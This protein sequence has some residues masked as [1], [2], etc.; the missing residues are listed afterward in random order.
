MDT[1]LL[2]L[3]ELMSQRAQPTSEQWECLTLRERHLESVQKRMG[4]EFCE[5][6]RDAV[7]E[8]AQLDAEEA[9]RW[10]LRLGLA[11]NRL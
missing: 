11:L 1:L 4:S 5:K 2:D 10:G 3:F 6:L 8:C 9:F 7:D